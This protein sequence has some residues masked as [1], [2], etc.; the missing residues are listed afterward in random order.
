MKTIIEV[1]NLSKKYKY[2]ELQP[3]YTLRDSVVDMIRSLINSFR[4]NKPEKNAEKDVFWALKNVSFKINQGEAV[5]IIGPNGAGKSTILKIL[6]RI[7]PPT[8]GRAVLTGRIGSLL[9]VGTGFQQELTGRENIYLNGA[10]LGMKKTEIDK[11]FDEIVEFSGIGKFLDTPVKHYSSGMYMRLAFAV[12]A[13]LDSEILIVDEVLAVGDGEF[14]KKCL[15]KMNN[16]VK[17][18]NRTILFVSHNL[19]AVKELCTRCILVSNG[20]IQMDGPTQSV[21]DLYNETVKQEH[22]LPLL[23]RKDRKGNGKI[24]VS[25]IVIRNSHGEITNHLTSG[26]DVE[27]EIR[28]DVLDRS[29]KEINLSLGVDSMATRNRIAFI[30]NKIISKK[31]LV[32]KHPSIRIKIKGMPF[33]SGDYTLTV[34]IDS[35][36][37]VLDWVNNASTFSIKSVD[38]FSNRNLLPQ[39][40]GDISLKYEII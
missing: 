2:G 36:G 14:Q 32:E 20:K 7:T 37:D 35:Y 23:K 31:I 6:S 18:E 9:E 24:K 39:G 30:G 22:S 25:G 19:D 34:F 26:E 27:I 4:K 8:E 10:I 29:I 13:H 11:K 21:I 15:G 3:Y 12:A 28:M 38:N 5:G 16:I 33:L 1:T 17:N 40:Q